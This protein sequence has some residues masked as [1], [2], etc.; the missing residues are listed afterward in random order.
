[1]EN[2]FLIDLRARIQNKSNHGPLFAIQSDILPLAMAF[3]VE[4]IELES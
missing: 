2:I 3:F 1:M 4:I